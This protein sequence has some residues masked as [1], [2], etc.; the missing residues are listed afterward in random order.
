M[1]NFLISFPHIAEAIF[2]SLDNKSLQNCLQVCT[3]WKNFLENEEF[4][5]RRLTKGHPGW[6]VLLGSKKFQIMSVLAK[7]FFLMKEDKREQIHPSLPR[8]DSPK[9]APWKCPVECAKR[10]NKLVFFKTTA[11]YG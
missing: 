9:R 8:L 10:L 3:S 7:S 11:V 4:F 6:D 2:K 1:E 5:W